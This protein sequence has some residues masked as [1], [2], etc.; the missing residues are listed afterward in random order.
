MRW[1]PLDGW[2]ERGDWWL[3]HPE[4]KGWLRSHDGRWWDAR[5]YPRAVL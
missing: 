3:I 5:E 4:Y 2:I 1:A